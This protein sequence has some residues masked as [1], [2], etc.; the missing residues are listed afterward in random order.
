M[1]EVLDELG[2][3]LAFCDCGMRIENIQ[4]WLIEIYNST[5]ACK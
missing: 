4:V 2:T 1:F 5:L 3:V